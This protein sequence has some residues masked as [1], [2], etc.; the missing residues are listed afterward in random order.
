[1]K[2]QDIL[3]N[4]VNKAYLSL[5]SNL[6]KK[7]K[8]LELAKFLLNSIGINVL[9]TSNFYKTKS[10]PN[11]NFP[12]YLN[13]VILVNTKFGLIEL[14][15]KIKII[16]KSIGRKN[17]IK[18]YPRV[19]DIDIIDFNGSRSSTNYLEQKIIVPHKRMHKRNFV[20]MPLYEISKNWI[21]P[22]FNKNIVKLISSLSI[23]GLS[24][25]KL[26]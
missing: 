21:H 15:N 22:K 11:K 13:I 16:E 5:G 2:K 4:Q 6:G 25:I 10:W 7:V 18:N 23:K 1:M 26:S 14:F 9:K 3:E 20:L 24:S 19:C 17:S 12:D 8:N